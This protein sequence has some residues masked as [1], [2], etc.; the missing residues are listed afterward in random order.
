MSRQAVL[1]DAQGAVDDATIAGRVD[2]LSER[3][4]GCP[5]HVVALLADNGIDWLVADRAIRQANRVA[6]P[7]PTFFTDAQCRHALDAAG[8]P[9]LLT[10]D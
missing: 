10:D 9:V 7:L 6:L 1:I 2:A 4:A 3:L 8:A 5:A